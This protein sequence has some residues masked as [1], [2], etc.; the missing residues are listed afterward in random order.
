[1]DGKEKNEYNR[2]KNYKKNESKKELSVLVCM[3]FVLFCF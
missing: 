2:K 3:G 1:M